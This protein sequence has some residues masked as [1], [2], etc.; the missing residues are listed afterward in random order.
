MSDDT[1]QEG[2]IEIRPNPGPQESY[3]STTADVA[4]FGGAAGGGKSYS[5]LMQPLAHIDNAGFG[6]IIFRR[7]NPQIFNEGALWDISTKLYPMLRARPRVA[8]A[9]WIFPSG[10]KIRFAHMEH[11][12]SKKEWDGSQVAFIGFDELTSFTATMFWYMLSRNRSTCGIRPYMRATCNPDADSWV[13]DLV[14]W[15][16]NQE[17]GY[18]IPE[19]SG[20]IRWFI[21]EDGKLVWFDSKKEA[22]RHLVKGG[23]EPEKAVNQPK[24]FTFIP[25]RL[26]DNPILESVDPGY[27]ANLQ[28]MER[29]ER[30]RLLGGNW[31]IRPASGLKFPRDKWRLYDEAPS[32]LRLCRFWDKAG[33]EGGKG[34]RTAGGLLG[35]LDAARAKEL[36]LPRFWVVH[37]AAERW[38]D[39]ERESQIAML[40]KLD[41]EQYGHVTIGMEQEPGSGGK[42][43]AFVTITNLAGFDVFAERATTNKSARWTPFASQQQVGNVAV[44]RGD[45]DWAGMI[46]ELDALAGDARTAYG[47]Y[48]GLDRGKL[49]DIADALSGAFKFLTTGNT[50]QIG[51]DMLASGNDPE[52]HKPF[53]AQEIDELPDFL[54]DIVRG[55][56]DLAR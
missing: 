30:E 11:E 28:A 19:R 56:D 27:R 24:S 32:G 45:W 44:V 13:A 33:T 31:K 35:E 41:A 51:G 55:S 18:P 9:E 37:V 54:R 29:V 3:L 46:R 36:G 39:A 2:P 4:L 49:K 52:E 26:E 12:K 21:R 34:A 42:H 7:T 16:I 47:D 1:Y 23:L 43:S 50:A 22:A 40:A 38:N 17:T 14:A 5:L 6:A 8:R 25:A 10:A 15:W 20:V 53:D 48:E